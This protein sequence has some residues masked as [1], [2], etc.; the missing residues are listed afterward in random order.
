MIGERNVERCSVTTGNGNPTYNY[1]L[2]RERIVE[3]AEL[4][5][6]QN[7]LILLTPTGYIRLTKNFYFKETPHYVPEMVPFDEGKYAK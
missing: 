7:H 5:Y 6:L 1:S 3:P 2:Q 4:A